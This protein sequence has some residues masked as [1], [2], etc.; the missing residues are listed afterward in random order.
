MEDRALHA[1]LLLRG[2]IMDVVPEALYWYRYR[3]D[4]TFRSLDRSSGEER[5]ARIYE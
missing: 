2:Y 1:R 4:S 3:D 5:L